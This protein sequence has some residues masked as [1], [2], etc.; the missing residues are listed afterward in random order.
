MARWL[1]SPLPPRWLGLSRERPPAV[2]SNSGS[3][4]L[5]QHASLH[6]LRRREL[7]NV[8]E[9]ER[10]VEHTHGKGC[11][12]WKSVFVLLTVLYCGGFALNRTP[13][14]ASR[15]TITVTPIADQHD[16]AVAGLLQPRLI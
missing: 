5:R 11:A 14:Q 2:F 16:A 13:F 3:K 10:D 1:S 4:N 15:D 9:R 6:L 12:T 7:V 8:Q